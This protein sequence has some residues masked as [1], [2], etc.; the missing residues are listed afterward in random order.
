MKSN[1]SRL[2]VNFF[3]ALFVISMFVTACQ[4]N[5]GGGGD[6]TATTPPPE[7]TCTAGT[8][9]CV[10]GTL[11]NANYC[12]PGQTCTY[13]QNYGYYN[14]GYYQQWGYPTYNL[15]AVGSGYCGCPAGSVPVMNQGWGIGCMPYNYSYNNGFTYSVWNYPGQNQGWVNVPQVYYT[16]TANVYN[17]S[18]NCYP[19]AGIACDTRIANSCGSYGTCVVTSASSSVGV[20]QRSVN[21]LPSNCTTGSIG[22]SWYQLD[23][24]TCGGVGYLPA[25]ER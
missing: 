10:N 17:N 6:K 12:I 22:R 23:Y 4:N 24:Y 7:N 20:C 15:Q 3:S 14:S 16:S 18:N 1:N 8:Q 13:G 9:G 19:F 21:Q 25:G 2:N 11:V 5:S